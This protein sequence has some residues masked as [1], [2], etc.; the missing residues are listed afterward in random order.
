MR[1]SLLHSI[2]F[3]T[4]VA[5]LALSYAIFVR[6]SPQPVPAQDAAVCDA[7]TGESAEAIFRKAQDRWSANVYP[8][9]LHYVLTISATDA[10]GEAMVRHYD[11]QAEPDRDVIWMHTRSREEAA[12]PP[13]TPHG[14]NFVIAIQGRVV[15]DFNPKDVGFDI[16]GIPRL[17]PVYAFG[18]TRE[19]V[20][21]T[22]PP[23]ANDLNTIATVQARAR[24]YRVTCI[25][26]AASDSGVA[27]DHLRLE[28]LRD[29]NRYR[30]RE[31]WIESGS[32]WTVRM[33]LARNFVDGPPLHS[34]WDIAFA[35]DE[36]AEYIASE[37]AL[38]PLDYGRGRIYRDVTLEFE[39]TNPKPSAVSAFIFNDQP[40]DENALV[41]P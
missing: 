24:E 27:V 5:T 6:V 28:P 7:R 39:R 12:Q 36:R 2:H 4:R 20:V 29:P 13:T 22:P 19:T 37:R 35:H 33:L 26:N 18:M 8:Y 21:P 23:I 17:S 16:M 34:T 3:A 25:D 31:V 14:I 11:G 15:H 38:M 30:I 32:Y 1:E 41:E 10:R 40:T 9:D